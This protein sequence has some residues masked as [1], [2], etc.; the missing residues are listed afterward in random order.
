[1]EAPAY[2]FVSFIG[3]DAELQ[4]H[5]GNCASQPT[6]FESA[7]SGA[8]ERDRGQ[9]I[10]AGPAKNMEIG[11]YRVSGRIIVSLGVGFRPKRP[12]MFG[13]AP[14]ITTARVVEAKS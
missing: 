7:D 13:T 10:R 4:S 5:R 9:T 11:Q 3:K 6:G 8:G 12:A 14:A 2:S 1:M